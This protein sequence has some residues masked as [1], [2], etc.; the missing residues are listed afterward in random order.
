[1]ELMEEMQLDGDNKID[2]KESKTKSI[3]CN[4]FNRGFCK[5]GSLCFVNH[6]KDDYQEHLV[7]RCH[8]PWCKE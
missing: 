8:D 2:R 3:M 4:F 5:E 6:P 1:M 7:A